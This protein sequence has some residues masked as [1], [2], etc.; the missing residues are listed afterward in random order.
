MARITLKQVALAGAVIAVLGSCLDT[1]GPTGPTVSGAVQGQVLKNDGSAVNNAVLGFTF[2]T[3]PVNGTAR[4]LASLP[5]NTDDEG[6]FT[7]SFIASDTA[8]FGEVHISVSPPIGSQLADKDTLH[9]PIKIWNGY[10]PGDTA[11]VE[12]RLLPRQ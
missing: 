10:P 8:M 7:A 3:V 1:S 11:Y 6:R 4:F 5:L 2:T 12:I 9:I